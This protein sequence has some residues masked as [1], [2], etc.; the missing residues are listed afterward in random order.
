MNPAKKTIYTC[1]MHPEVTQDHPGD[2]PKCGMYLEPMAV[3]MPEPMDDRE[4]R[5]MTRRFW[6]GTVLTL[7]LFGWMAI[8][9]VPGYSPGNMGRAG[10]FQ[11]ALATPVVLVCGWPLWTKAWRSLILR[12]LNMFTLIGLGVLVSYLYSL[13]AFFIPDL[14]P[15]AFRNPDGSVPVYFEAAAGITV[16]ALMGQVMELRARNQ[17]GAAIQRLLGLS[18]KNARKVLFDGSETDVPLAM[19]QVGDHLRVRPGEKVPVDGVVLEGRSLVDES[20][21]TGEPMLVEK[22]PRDKV[23]GATINGT[24]SFLIQAEKIGSDTLLSRIVSMVAQAQRSRAPVQKLADAVS[25]Y[26][27]PAVVGAALVTAVVWYLLGPPP[28]FAHALVNAVAVLIIACPC[29]LG[30]ATPMSIMAATGKGA[31]V[32]V[33]FRDAEA[34]ETLCR[35]DTLV[36]DKTGTLT[37]GKPR[38]VSIIPWGGIEE[39]ELLRWAASLERGSEHPLAAAIVK[40]AEERNIGLEKVEEFESMTGQ[41]IR[42]LIGIHRV[43]LGNKKWME[44]LGVDVTASSAQGLLAEGQT[45]VFLAVDGRAAGILGAADPIKESTRDAIRLLH[46]EGIRVIMATGDNETTARFVADQLGLDGIAAGVLPTGKAEKI[47]QLQSEGCFVAM[48]GDGINDAPALAQAQV[49]IA[50]G[51]GTDIAM[52]SAGITLVKGD[53]RGIA[54][55]RALSRHTM[56]NIRQNL[57]FAFFYNALGIP[58][59]AGVL[60]PFFGILLSPIIA[61]LAMSFSSISVILNSLRLR[62]LKI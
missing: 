8:E 60:Y 62:N 26:F 3:S 42:G 2:C 10:L 6:A 30:L 5:D 12:S 51:T 18:A 23:V 40:V 9:M 31:A 21:V 54:R 29:A 28:P 57:F 19:V 14:F 20:M 34:I 47:R 36:V 4:L 7:P 22:G 32:G 59:A 35:V 61:A 39:P 44:S 45:V 1:P 56:A 41:G 38:I 58:V 25:G 11:A 27:V 53:L 55:A 50:M 46:G 33:L 13:T 48:A 15:T 16:L 24:G 49:G 43:A 37:E 17:T 52:E